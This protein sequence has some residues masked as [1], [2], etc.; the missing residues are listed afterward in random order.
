MT[1]KNEWVES[2]QK[3]AVYKQRIEND[4]RIIWNVPFYM[5]R[6]YG[7]T[8]I[9]M[10]RILERMHQ[11]KIKNGKRGTVGMAFKR[12]TRAAKRLKETFEKDPEAKWR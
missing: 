4:L 3:V 1:K 6:V 2:L 8:C 12:A 9:K 5:M 10:G 7:Y 11:R